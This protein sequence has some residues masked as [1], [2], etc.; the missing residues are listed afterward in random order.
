MNNNIYITLLGN[1]SYLQGVLL[2]NYSLKQVKSKYPLLVLV[3][4]NINTATKDI[5]SFLDIPYKEIPS[6]D[7]TELIKINQER[8]QLYIKQGKKVRDTW[9]FAGLNKFQIFNQI[10]YDKII[11]LDCDIMVL[12]NIDHLFNELNISVTNQRENWNY[13]LENFNSGF[14]IFEPSQQIYQDLLKLIKDRN[15]LNNEYFKQFSYF[16]DQIL[17]NYYFRNLQNKIKIHF[18]DKYY[19]I[20]L[21]HGPHFFPTMEEIETY[22]YFIHFLGPIKPWDI[23]N[24][25]FSSSYTLQEKKRIMYYNYYWKEAA[26]II[27]QILLTLPAKLILDF[28]QVYLKEIKSFN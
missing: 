3:T 28:S 11:Y 27:E 15:I 1:N 19:N 10:Q 20:Q 9:S 2:L 14:I 25:L 23:G 21:T 17:L 16:G 13:P 6:I 4:Q 26:N 8:K 18:L 22:G 5:L 24:R 7:F 12:K